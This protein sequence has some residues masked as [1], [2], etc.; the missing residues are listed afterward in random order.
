MPIA[1]LAILLLAECAAI[2]F[3]VRIA[4]TQ[5]ESQA[6]TTAHAREITKDRPQPKEASE[7]LVRLFVAAEPLRGRPFQDEHPLRSSADVEFI[8]KSILDDMRNFNSREILVEPWRRVV[9]IDGWVFHED[10]GTFE[11]LFKLPGGRRFKLRGS[12]VRSTGGKWVAEVTRLVRVLPR[13][14]ALMAPN[15]NQDLKQIVE[16]ALTP[17]EARAA[18]LRWLHQ[19]DRPDSAQQPLDGA[20]PGILAPILPYLRSNECREEL[21]SAGVAEAGNSYAIDGWVV[22]PDDL[23]FLKL[24][25]RYPADLLGHFEPTPNWEWKIVADSF[26]SDLGRMISR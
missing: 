1:T 13:A 21:A 20:A 16:L 22:D 14:E 3:V 18:L 9:R 26:V 6:A 10:D 2:Y 7:A 8:R 11:K 23:T 5:V 17:P 4:R 15:D 19:L 12:F 25:P 24:K